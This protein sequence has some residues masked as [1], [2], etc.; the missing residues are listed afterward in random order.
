MTQRRAALCAL[1]LL[2]IALLVASASCGGGGSTT[3]PAVFD[4]A[5]AISPDGTLQEDVLH[6][7]TDGRFQIEAAG[8]S[9]ALTADGQPLQS[10]S[11][12][13]IADPPAP[14]PGAYLLAPAYDLGPDGATFDPPVTATL[15]YDPADFPGG[16][17]EDNLYIAFYNTATGQWVALP[18]TVDTTAHTI[19]AAVSHFTQFA[20]Y[21]PI[22]VTTPTP[23]PSP[24]PSGLPA[25][26]VTGTSTPGP[27]PT[28]VPT[29]AGASTPTPSPTAAGATP[30][31]VPAGGG[32]AAPAV[33]APTPTP[34][35]SHF[36]DVPRIT[37]QEVK[38]LLDADA[39]IVV[40]DSRSY[41]EYAA[42]RIPGAISLPLAGMAPPYTSLDSYDQ[43]ITYCT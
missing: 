12:E 37:P 40:I 21:S 1:S 16:M 29:S 15:T 25:P 11:V 30:T 7:S 26:A 23:P 36:P 8:G 17:S 32:G 24:S 39:N 33:P 4:L 41:A 9:K 20:L 2:A 35:Y 18:S 10:L 31:P 34:T 22:T 27:T 13:E 5:G 19:T 3:Q 38:A 28:S 14:P 6:V 43:I 42:A